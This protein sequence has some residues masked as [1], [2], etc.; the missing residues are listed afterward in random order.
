MRIFK[1][2]IKNISINYEDIKLTKLINDYIDYFKELKD[3][4]G[5][6]IFHHLAIGFIKEPFIRDNDKNIN[7]NIVI[8][9]NTDFERSIDNSKYH[10]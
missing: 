3:Y 2:F 7:I 5:N 6:T 9:D 1:E 8:K 4:N 10:K